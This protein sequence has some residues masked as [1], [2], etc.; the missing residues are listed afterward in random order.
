MN[1]NGLKPYA[2]FKTEKFYWAHAGI[3][4]DLELPVLAQMV[5]SRNNMHSCDCTNTAAQRT[6][7]MREENAISVKLYLLLIVL[8]AAL[9]CTW[10][11]LLIQDTPEFC[12]QKEEGFLTC[13]RKVTCYR[14]SYLNKSYNKYSICILGNSRRN[15]L[16]TSNRIIASYYYC[17]AFALYSPSLHVQSECIETP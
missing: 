10:L 16:E 14:T 11:L 3:S 5:S 2:A 8:W 13:H 4:R 6:N 7:N 1:S 9:C 15:T 17:F 12:M